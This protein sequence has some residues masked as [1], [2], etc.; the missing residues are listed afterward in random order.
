MA[1]PTLARWNLQEAKRRTQHLRHLETVCVDPIKR[2]CHTTLEP[3]LWRLTQHRQLMIKTCPILPCWPCCMFLCS[4]WTETINKK[5]PLS[6]WLWSRLRLNPLRK[7]LSLHTASA[8]TTVHLV[9]SCERFKSQMVSLLLIL[10][11]TGGSPSG[12]W[13]VTCIDQGCAPLGSLK[14][15]DGASDSLK[16]PNEFR[17]PTSTSTS[18]CTSSRP[19]QQ[20]GWPWRD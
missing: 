15:W 18:I 5:L 1:I 20:N 7:K 16:K 17:A 2:G 19:T 14:V 13:Q 9:P 10:R 8:S 12:P 11:F 4:T 6:W 3:K